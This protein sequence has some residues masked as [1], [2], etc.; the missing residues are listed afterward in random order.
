MAQGFGKRS[1]VRF[2]LPLKVSCIADYQVFE[3]ETENVSR[4]GA[5]LKS[6]VAFRAGQGLAVVFNP[7]GLRS[8]FG[9]AAEVVWSS[10]LED[11]Q[12]TGGYQLGV[13]YHLSPDHRRVFDAVLSRELRA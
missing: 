4:S 7:P 10:R 8:I 9:V 5:L 2:R 11:E 12:G 3:A 13:R 1:E 6:P